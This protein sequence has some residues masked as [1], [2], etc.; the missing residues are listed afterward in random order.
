MDIVQ[1][2]KASFDDEVLPIHSY[3]PPSSYQTAI[4]T[5]TT[6]ATN[7]HT[8]SKKQ[9]TKLNTTLAQPLLSP[10]DNGD[11]SIQQ[12]SHQ[13][14]TAAD[15]QSQFW[16]SQNFSVYFRNISS[17]FKRRKID[18]IQRDNLINQALKITFGATGIFLIVVVISI[19][20]GLITILSLHD[21]HY[22]NDF[23]SS[24]L[25]LRSVDFVLSIKEKKQ[26][27][28]SFFPLDN[29]A[30]VNVSVAKPKVAALSCLTTGYRNGCMLFIVDVLGKRSLQSFSIAPLT[31]LFEIV[32]VYNMT[33]FIGSTLE[34]Q[35]TVLNTG[36]TIALNGVCR[37]FCFVVE[38]KNLLFSVNPRKEENGSVPLDL[39]IYDISF[40]RST[41]ELTF[42]KVKTLSLP[43]VFIYSAKNHFVVS[44][45]KI[46]KRNFVVVHYQSPNLF[47]IDL[48]T[49]EIVGNTTL[50]LPVWQVGGTAMVMPYTSNLDI[51][52]T[53]IVIWTMYKTRFNNFVFDKDFNVISNGQI[54]LMLE[55]SE[56]L[57]NTASFS[58]LENNGFVYL[59]IGKTDGTFFW[60]NSTLISEGIFVDSLFG[61]YK[62]I[63][64]HAKTKGE[65]FNLKIDNSEAQ[66]FSVEDNFEILRL[67]IGRFDKSVFGI[68]SRTI[69]L[70]HPVQ[71]EF[72]RIWDLYLP[73]PSKRIQAFYIGD[74]H[75]FMFDELMNV[76]KFDA[77][78]LNQEQYLAY[79]DQ[80]AFYFDSIVKR[81]P[82]QELLMVTAISYSEE[83]ER[84]SFRV[85]YV[86]M[87]S[88]AWIEGPTM[89]FTDLFYDFIPLNIDPT[90]KM[91]YFLELYDEKTLL[92]K[93]DLTDPN[94]KIVVERIATESFE[95]CEFIFKV[96]SSSNYLFVGCG[97]VFYV[98]NTR[99][100][101][102]HAS[103]FINQ[104][105]VN[106]EPTFYDEG[107]VDLYLE[108]DRSILAV[109]NRGQLYRY[110]LGGWSNQLYTE[111]TFSIKKESSSNQNFTLCSN[112]GVVVVGELNKEL[113]YI[114]SLETLTSSSRGILI[115]SLTSI[116]LASLCFSTLF[117]FIFYKTR[118]TLLRKQMAEKNFKDKL[119]KSEFNYSA[120]DL[121]FTERISEGASGV[122]FK[123]SFKG[124]DVAIKKMKITDTDDQE[125]EIFEKEVFLL[126]SLRHPNVLSFIGV[127]I[128]SSDELQHYQ[129]II[130]EF[131]DNG[132]LD[133]YMRKLR[134]KFY[135]ET[136]LDILMDICRGMVYLHYKGIIHRDLKPQNILLTKEGTAKIGDFGIS[137]VQNTQNTMT[138]QTGTLEYISPEVLQ[139]I[140]YSEKCD[141]YSFAMIMY[142]VLFECK[143]YEKVA[144]LN[145]FTLALKVLGGLRP[146]IP[147]DEE[148]ND[149]VL[150][151]IKHNGISTNLSS[152]HLA[153]VIL[154]YVRLMRQCWSADDV[155]RPSFE[156]LLDKF[157]TMR[158]LL[159][160]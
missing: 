104:C 90:Y 107:F 106:K 3:S 132:S 131:M 153:Q 53:D 135:M 29:T 60:Y 43:N 138:G 37:R 126:K 110:R 150:E 129:F 148:N 117:G 140:R 33:V 134:G 50:N 157:A 71:G 159:D 32:H 94:L 45:F 112:S 16:P 1:K 40:D 4:M 154:D 73:A 17:V 152:H 49:L 9:K 31:Y 46:V 20:V 22:L 65:Q 109:T 122:V 160:H 123:G 34:N 26:E 38:H 139:Q 99:T 111:T 155:S 120:S 141:V 28:L 23:G 83:N 143:P 91:G 113:S 12:P 125:Q 27:W 14:S 119:D 70:L 44:A 89:H 6:T 8:S 97:C 54:T 30:S 58:K 74:Y 61:S 62:N 78:Y 64:V 82:G 5:E 115:Y 42:N 2:P 75:I 130:T 124:T 108:N 103:T 66:E 39:D 105:D 41:L 48:N 18:A 24:A 13:P 142:E 151:F 63:L 98:F 72:K 118:N 51:D 95:P 101:E 86:N 128:G 85:N 10:E 67:E 56:A 147:F 149:Q 96:V 158:G 81:V 102:L 100:L 136:K 121:Q 93:R 146:S 35:L 84:N 137:R 145:M 76:Y 69:S 144:D 114:Y 116:L 156:Q 36:Q 88:M 133:R 55:D 11:Y 127:C 77:L 52:D 92:R 15:A 7:T 47:K 19:F 59:Q 79:P 25:S 80:N 57:S 21:S 87:S 68:G